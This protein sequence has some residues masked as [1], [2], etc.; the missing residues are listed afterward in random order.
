MDSQR[1]SDIRASLQDMTM[2]EIQSMSDDLGRLIS[3]LLTRQVAIEQEIC[4]RFE[5]MFTK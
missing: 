4:E 2:D 3:V 5:V 1:I